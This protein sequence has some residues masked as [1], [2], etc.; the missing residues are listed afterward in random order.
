V[1]VHREVLPL[2]DS[3]EDIRKRRPHIWAKPTAR[4]MMYYEDSKHQCRFE[5]ACAKPLL[6]FAYDD[7]RRQGEFLGRAEVEVP[8]PQVAMET[9]QDEKSF[10]VR[11]RI[12]EGREFPNYKIAVWN[13]PRKSAKYQ[14]QT[15]AK[16]FMLVENQEGDYRGILVFD[17][18]PE[19][20]VRLLLGRKYNSASPL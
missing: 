12:T 17:L 5:Y 19:I 2:N 9:R 8:D 18:K 6:W 14:P 16:E 1:D 13:I 3:L 10:E 4:E 7:H 20:E 11:F 15:N